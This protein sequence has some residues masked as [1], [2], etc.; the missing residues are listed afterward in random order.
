[1]DLSVRIDLLLKPED[2]GLA[3]EW[4]LGLLGLDPELKGMPSL[5]LLS[6]PLL[7]LPPQPRLLAINLEG[8]L[9]QAVEQEGMP[10][11]VLR[12]LP[13]LLPLLPPLLEMAPHLDPL[14]GLVNQWVPEKPPQPLH[15][16]LVL[17]LPLLQVVLDQWFNRTCYH[18]LLCPLMLLEGMLLSGRVCLS[19]YQC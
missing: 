3:R 16:P 11:E 4:D 5:P 19:S 10:D 7:S 13:P 9:Q 17:P 2:L 14:L 8:A 12:L 15:I 6:M 1:M 18:C